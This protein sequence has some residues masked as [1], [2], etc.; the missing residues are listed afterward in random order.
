MQRTEIHI[1]KKANHKRLSCLLQRDDAFSRPSFWFHRGIVCDFTHKPCKWQLPRQQFDC[2]LVLTG[3]TQRARARPVSLA[4]RPAWGRWRCFRCSRACFRFWVQLGRL[5]SKWSCQ[6][7][8]TNSFA[9]WFD[10]RCFP[11]M[12]NFPSFH[13]QTRQ[14]D[15]R[16]NQS[17]NFLSQRSRRVPLKKVKT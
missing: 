12:T 9:D 7:L 14:C 5:R 2:L 16:I 3:F 8:A 17:T 15:K 13:I 1:F 11:S 10:Q 4:L 6:A